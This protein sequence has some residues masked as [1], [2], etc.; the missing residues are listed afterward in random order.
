MGVPTVW[1]LSDNNVIVLRRPPGRPKSTET[2]RMSKGNPSAKADLWYAAGLELQNVGEQPFAVDGN[3]GLAFPATVGSDTI[4][5]LVAL[6]FLFL[7]S[8]KAVQQSSSLRTEFA[9]N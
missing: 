7:L 1:P 6:E 4:Q 3:G 8:G 9:G 5:P 2:R